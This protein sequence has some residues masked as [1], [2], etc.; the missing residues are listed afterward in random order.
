MAKQQQNEFKEMELWEHLDELRTRLIRSVIYVLVGLCVAWAVYP[1]L[2]DLFFAPFK[3]FAEKYHWE[4]VWTSFQQ[5]FMFQLQM[6]LIAG[7]IIA[8]PL[9]TLEAWGFIAPG[10][11]RNERRACYLIFPMSIFFFLFG[12]FCGY[13]L[14]PTTIGYFASFVSE[15]E[16]VLQAPALYLTFAV[17]MVVAFGAC[18]QMP[19]ILMFLCWIDLV[20]SRLLVEQWRFAVV[21]CFV[22][23]A[24]ATP[25]ADPLTMTIMA[26]PLAFLYLVSIFLCKLVERA[27]ADRS[28]RD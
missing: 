18:F 25:S 15:Q 9:V 22:V 26:L 24:V 13:S 12:V 21:G 19:V 2:R 23:A 6:S 27:R 17:K 7:L 8:I 20:S 4:L 10:L 3:P 1:W 11:T 14:L 16:K 5:A 28:R